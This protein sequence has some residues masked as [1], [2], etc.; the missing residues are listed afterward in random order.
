[1]NLV[2][3]TAQGFSTLAY[4]PDHY[5][6]RVQGGAIH[7]G[8]FDMT[9]ASTHQML[10][11]SPL[12]SHENQE[13]LVAYSLNNLFQTHTYT[14]LPLLL[15]V[16]YPIIISLISVPNRNSVR[17]CHYVHFTDQKNRA[18]GETVICPR[19]QNQ[20]SV[21]SDSNQFWMPSQ[22]GSFL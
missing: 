20:E 13:H 12:P 16:C 15:Q 8:M 21:E 9:L 18:Q 5:L 11:A 14:Q 7:C 1:M 22:H 10:V 4:G 19:F 6:L 3:H 2:I 17:S